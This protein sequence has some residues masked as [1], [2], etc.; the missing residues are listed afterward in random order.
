VLP[1]PQP[2]TTKHKHSNETICN[3]KLMSIKNISSSENLPAQTVSQ[4]LVRE[5]LP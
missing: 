5:E 3:Q 1:V 4:P 2:D